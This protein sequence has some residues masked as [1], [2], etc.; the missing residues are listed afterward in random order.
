MGL[1]AGQISVAEMIIK[2]SFQPK[3]FYEEMG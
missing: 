2:S 1:G 3:P